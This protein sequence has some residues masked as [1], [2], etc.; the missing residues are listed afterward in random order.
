MRWASTMSDR[1]TEAEAIAAFHRWLITAGNDNDVIDE[2]SG[3]FCHH[4]HT[5]WEMAVRGELVLRLNGM[6]EDP[7]S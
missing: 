7:A 5:V 3:L 1:G 4:L 2:A 6:L